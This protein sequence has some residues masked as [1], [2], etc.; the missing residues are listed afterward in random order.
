MDGKQWMACERG[1]RLAM[2][3]VAGDRLCANVNKS[4]RHVLR[5]STRGAAEGDPG[6]G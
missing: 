5:D 4:D 2:V 3:L 6:L 1:L